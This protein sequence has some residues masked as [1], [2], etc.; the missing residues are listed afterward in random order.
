MALEVL[1]EAGIPISRS[2]W[3]D[4]E[5]SRYLEVERFDRVG[6]QGRRGVISLFALNCHYLVGLG[7]VAFG[8]HEPDAQNRELTEEANSKNGDNRW[9]DRLQVHRRPK[10]GDQR[11]QAHKDA[12]LP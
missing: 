3:F 12:R 2:E 7:Q 8:Q 9:A 6:K 10:P 1:C 11:Y 5:G 4:L